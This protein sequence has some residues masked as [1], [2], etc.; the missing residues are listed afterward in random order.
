MEF[1]IR[2]KQQPLL[3]NIFLLAKRIM[4]NNNKLKMLNWVKH[5]DQVLC[6]HWKIFNSLTQTERLYDQMRKSLLEVINKRK[7]EGKI[8]GIKRYIY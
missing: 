6:W 7:K 5:P 3:E 8:K 1:F 2:K 4:P